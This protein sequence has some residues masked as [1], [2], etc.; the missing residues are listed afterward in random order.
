MLRERGVD[1]DFDVVSNPEFLREGSAVNDFMHPDRIVIGTQSNKAR[2]T[3][4]SVYRVLYINN[5]PF[6]FTNVETAEVIK[7]ASNAFLATKITFINEIANLCEAVGANV[8]QV[9]NAIG[10]DKRIGKYFL[11]AGPGYGGSCF[12]KDTKALVN[13]GKEFGVEMS[14]IDSVINA[15]DLHKL[16]MVDKITA[17]LGDVEGKT[18]AVLGLSFK[19]ETDDVRE[20]PFSIHCARAAPGGELTSAP[21]TRRLWR[22]PPVRLFRPSHRLRSGRVRLRGRRPRGGSGHR[23]EPVSQ[24]GSRTDEKHHGGSLLF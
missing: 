22:M 11:H 16:K 3:M 4:R 9:S 12:P 8:Q 10:L 23:M 18:I 15:N 1:Y 2:K 13:T 19:P 21:M 5:H 7:Y 24:P 17:A 20:A 6:V 14:L